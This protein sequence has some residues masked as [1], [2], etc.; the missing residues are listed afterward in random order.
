MFGAGLV[1]AAS[2]VPAD[3]L[4]LAAVGAALSASATIVPL[5]IL[6]ARERLR[7][8]I[9]LTALQVL[10]TPTLTILLVAIL[11]W[12][13]T[14]WMLAYLIGNG[15][16]L[17]RGLLVI[18]HRWSRRF[19]LELLGASLAFGIP[20]VPHALS[21]WGLSVSDRAILGAFVPAQ[22]VGEYY[23]AYLACLPISLLAISTA[24][25]SQPLFSE[26]QN[27]NDDGFGV[28]WMSSIQAALV[29]GTA[30]AVALLGPPI[31]A[32]ALPSDYAGTTG[33]IPPLAFGTALFGLYLMPMN[34][35]TLSA[36]RTSRIW[37]ITVVAALANVT[38]N[39]ALIPRYGA[40]AAAVNTIVAYGLLLVG[41][42]LYQRRVCERPLRYDLR[43]LM[44]T[45]LI[46]G[47]P[48]AGAAALTPGDTW[49]GLGTRTALL[50]VS[51]VCVMAWPFR[52]DLMR[53][54]DGIGGLCDHR[55][56]RR[57]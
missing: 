2:D 49:V 43:R 22:A 29:V 32:L 17:I 11:G 55:G 54:L 53:A 46:I 9:H 25:A 5:A 21:H 20:L 35:V 34:A 39:L 52:R 1:A 47:L 51:T 24:Q 26:G 31:V 36:G 14:G 56:A 44:V 7:D 8:Y 57:L 16:L 27:A 38:L 40:P 23:V 15:V 19:D 28:G 3:A 13:V 50:A 4:R 30:I 18:G 48:A 12:G 41:V 45:V 42:T 10:V 6:R 33:L 37:L